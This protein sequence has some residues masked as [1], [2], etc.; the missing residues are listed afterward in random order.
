MLPP[1]I[2]SMQLLE[3]IK[4]MVDNHEDYIP[5]ADGVEGAEFV[6]VNYFQEGVWIC[7]HHGECAMSKYTKIQQIL[8]AQTKVGRQI[9]K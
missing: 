2:P 4:S 6:V 5:Q 1:F 3:Q 8:Q 7:R 9:E